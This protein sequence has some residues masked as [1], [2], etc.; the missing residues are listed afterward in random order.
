MGCILAWA[1]YCTE[2]M[3][4]V[5]YKLGNTTG[6]LEVIPV[7]YRITYTHQNELSNSIDKSKF[8]V[9]VEPRTVA[10]FDE[11]TLTWNIRTS[12]NEIWNV[13]YNERIDDVHTVYLY[14]D[15]LCWFKENSMRIYFALKEKDEN[16][17]DFSFLLQTIDIQ[18]SV[19]SIDVKTDNGS[20]YTCKYNK[21]MDTIEIKLISE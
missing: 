3:L 1:V 5:S 10:R 12:N 14:T 6:R 15:E 18:D 16:V 2:Q 19:E 11:N 8:P 7:E 17:K 9:D 13:M 21:D 4:K 20:V